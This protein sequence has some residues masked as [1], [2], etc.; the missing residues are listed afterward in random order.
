MNGSGWMKRGLRLL[1]ATAAVV[2]LALTG[3]ANWP[4][5]P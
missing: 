1:A 5:S 2:A 3:A 4:K